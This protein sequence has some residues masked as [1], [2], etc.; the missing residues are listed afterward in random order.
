MVTWTAAAV[1]TEPGTLWYRFVTRGFDQPRRIVKD[2]GPEASFDWAPHERE[3]L[4]LIEVTVRNRATGETAAA[5]VPFQATSNVT[6]GEPVVKETAHPLVMLYSAPPCPAGASMTV[7]Y[8]L[9]ENPLQNAPPKRCDGVFS[10]N[11]YLAGLRPESS[12]FVKHIIEDR[13]VFTEGPVLSFVSGEAPADLPVHS[14]FTGSPV[15]AEGVYLSGSLVA[16]FIATD[17]DGRLIWYYPKP[18]TFLTHPE[19]GGYFF[20]INLDVA[21]DESR[22]IVRMFDLTGTT[23]LETNAERVNEQLE[24]MGRRR[25]NGFHHEARLLSDGNILVL[26]G[27]EQILTDVQGPGPINVLGDMILVLNRDLEVIWTWDTFDHLDV[28]RL[29]TQNDTCMPVACPPL[30]LAPTA[31]DWTH[32]NAVTETPEGN[33]LFSMRSQDW[34]IKI[35]YRRGTGSGSVLWRLGEGG[36]FTIV[37]DDPKPWFSHQHD[38]EYEDDGMITLFD[39]SNV[40]RA[41]DATAHSRGQVFQLDESRRVARLVMNADLGGYAFALGSAEKLSDGNYFFD[42][43]FRENATGIS[44]ETDPQGQVVYA[45]EGTAPKYRTFRLKDLYNQ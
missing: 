8:L 15:R 21:G 28:R 9:P 14:R 26:A 20:G 37:S 18:M 7:Y 27:V 23:V 1:D 35:D 29:A 32:G 43:G 45:I 25:I 30:Y 41:E 3:G 39:N 6:A 33:L 2:F 16:N 17:L 19:A 10:M 12:Y 34:V 31:N 40:R 5:V 44:V 38:A 24:A 13:G 11:F 36:D 4:Y 42:V 22:Q